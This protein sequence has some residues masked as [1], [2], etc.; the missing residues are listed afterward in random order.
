[1]GPYNT[2]LS[3][4]NLRELYSRVKNP[5][6]QAILHDTAKNIIEDNMISP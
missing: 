6:V 2:A 1:M 5:G 4:A 3:D